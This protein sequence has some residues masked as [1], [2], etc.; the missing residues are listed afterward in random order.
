MLGKVVVLFSFP[1]FLAAVAKGWR[2]PTHLTISHRPC[3]T[4][5]GSIFI[6]RVATRNTGLGSSYPVTKPGCLFGVINIADPEASMPLQVSSNIARAIVYTLDESNG[7]ALTDVT[8]GFWAVQSSFAAATSL[9]SVTVEGTDAALE[10]TGRDCRK[11]ICDSNNG[12][13]TCRLE[14]QILSS[15]AY[16][17]Y[18]SSGEKVRNAKQGTCGLN[19]FLDMQIISIRPGQ[20]C[21]SL[22]PEQRRRPLR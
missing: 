5:V 17:I 7:C 15:F 20:W 1:V 4:T 3:G 19:P 2:L 14:G 21:H 9:G 13:L 11:D 16:G 22:H 6:V 10:P 18:T 12:G 8:L